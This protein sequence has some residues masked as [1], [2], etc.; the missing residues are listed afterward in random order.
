MLRAVRA[1]LA[2]LRAQLAERDRSV[3]LL[4]DQNTALRAQ[5]ATLTERLAELERQQRQNP[6][7]SSKPPSVRVRPL[8]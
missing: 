1:E 5:L 6:R 2:E 8:V 4:T 7:N 3:V